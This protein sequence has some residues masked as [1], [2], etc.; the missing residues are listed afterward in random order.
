MP[1]VS[2]YLLA[3]WFI[4]CFVL[5]V[6]A[7][8]SE[9]NRS[10]ALHSWDLHSNR[11]SLFKNKNNPEKIINQ[12]DI[13]TPVFTAAPHTTGGTW[14]QLICP[15][16]NEWLKKMR[17]IW[18]IINRE[19]EQNPVIWRDMDGPGDYWTEWSKSEREKQIPYIH[20]YIEPLLL[21]VSVPTCA[22][23]DQPHLWCW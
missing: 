23:P 15:S 20:K 2:K 8:T 5:G 11:D 3:I 21:S 18:N 13:H 7:K 19:R 9:H 10:K 14:E 17:Y 22:F 12:K 1:Q 6:H 16:T 4:T